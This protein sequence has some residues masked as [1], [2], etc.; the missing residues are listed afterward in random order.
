MQEKEERLNLKGGFPGDSVVNN[1]PANAGDKRWIPGLGRSPEERN[2]SVPQ[3][4]CLGS[5]MDRG[6]SGGSS[7][8]D[9]KMSDTI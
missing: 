5:S 9:R 1:L 3:Y 4:S 2:G 8:W 6:T 7:S